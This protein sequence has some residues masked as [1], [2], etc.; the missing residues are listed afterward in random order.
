MQRLIA[1]S[2]WRESSLNVL[3]GELT[4]SV[5]PNCQV[6]DDCIAPRSYALFLAKKALDELLHDQD[7]A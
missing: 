3:E 5:Q 2:S 6:P 1:A 7:R 4:I